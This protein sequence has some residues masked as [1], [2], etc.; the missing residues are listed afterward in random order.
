[1]LWYAD[2]QV[3]GRISF[4]REERVYTEEKG[5]G[6]FSEKNPASSGFRRMN[7]AL[8]LNHF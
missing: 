7:I 8:R 5:F 2:V 1:M 3:S 6:I 4:S